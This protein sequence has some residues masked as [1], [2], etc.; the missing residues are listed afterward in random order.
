MVSFKKRN[1]FCIFIFL[2][3]S[4]PR[5]EEVGQLFSFSGHYQSLPPSSPV[6]LLRLLETSYNGGRLGEC[7]LVPGAASSWPSKSKEREER[8]RKKNEGTR[9]AGVELANP[10]SLPLLGLVF[11]F[12]LG[13]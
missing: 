6:G 10:P 7:S 11:F 1:E 5:V 2:A 9:L 3:P 12:F 13:G 4:S 8:K